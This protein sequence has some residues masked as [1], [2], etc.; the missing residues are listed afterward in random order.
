MFSKM[1]VWLSAKGVKKSKFST[2]A[3]E[4]KLTQK[5]TNLIVAKDQKFVL[6][7]ERLGI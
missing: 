6:K 7:K 4:L 1:A 3:T 5:N 2:H